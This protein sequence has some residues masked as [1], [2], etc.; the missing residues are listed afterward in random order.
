LCVEL[1]EGSEFGIRAEDQVDGRAGP[2]ELAVGAVATLEYVL[3][4][5][6]CLPLRAHVEQVHEEVVAQRPGPLGED[7]VFGLPG[8][9]IQVRM[10]PTSTVISGAVKFSMKFVQVQ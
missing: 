3:V 5:A 7:T 9:G 1:G 6:G 10:P 4:R 8:V 2:F